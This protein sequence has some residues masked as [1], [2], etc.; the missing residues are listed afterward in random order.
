M[1]VFG[2]AIVYSTDMAETKQWM[3]AKRIE[4]GP[5]AAEAELRRWTKDAATRI[6]F[7]TVPIHGNAAALRADALASR[8]DHVGSKL[9]AKTVHRARESHV[10][11]ILVAAAA[12][13]GGFLLGRW[14]KRRQANEAVHG[15]EH[16][17]Y[18]NGNAILMEQ[19]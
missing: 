7:R 3:T 18:L 4:R 19:R 8:R 15:Q 6:G 2:H 16:S 11:E 5:E 9:M 12:L 17:A 13:G 10:G 14:W 1:N